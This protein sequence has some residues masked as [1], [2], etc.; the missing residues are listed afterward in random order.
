MKLLDPLQYQIPAREAFLA[1]REE[2]NTALPNA[3][4][5][6]VGSSSIPGS[7]SKGDIDIC[8]VINFS[9]LEEA[10]SMLEEM[11]YV[12]KLDTLRTPE[13]CMLQSPR[14][15]IDLALQVIAKGSEFEFFMTFRDAMLKD[16]SLVEQYNQVKLDHWNL[17]PALYR[18]AKSK[19]IAAVLRVA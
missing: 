5:E 12:V 16:P 18:E 7:I 2:V 10:V 6:H 3:R 13:L 8:V 4:V 19:F 15:D 11:G 1:T 17:S 14:Q 9:E